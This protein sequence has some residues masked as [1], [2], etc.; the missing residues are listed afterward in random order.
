M[1]N[2][3]SALLAQATHEQRLARALQKQ[4]QHRLLVPRIQR[5]LRLLRLLGD[6]LIGL[7]CKLKAL[8][9]QPEQELAEA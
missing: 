5:Q 1:L 6:Q 8:A 7:G 9:T 2:P 3:N 4:R